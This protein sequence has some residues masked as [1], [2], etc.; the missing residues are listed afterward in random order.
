[1]KERKDMGKREEAH[2]SLMNEIGMAKA[3]LDEGRP[4][5]AKRILK[6]IIKEGKKQ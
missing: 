5:T 1:M 3:A 6:K 4:E 2:A